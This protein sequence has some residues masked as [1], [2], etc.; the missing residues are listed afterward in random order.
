MNHL[1]SGVP[2]L[3]LQAQ[4]RAVQP[5]IESALLRVAA[6]QICV[7]GPEVE[8]LE[9]VLAEYCGARFALGVSSGTDALLAALMALEIGAGDEVLVPTF[10]FFA[11]A[12]AVAR[13]GATPVFVDSEPRGGM[14]NVEDLERRA[15]PRTKAIIPVH[16]FGQCAAMD[17][18]TDFAK[19]RGIVVIEDAAQ[20]LGA[21]YAPE[22]KAGSMGEIA[23]FSF[24]P[25]KNLGALGDAGLITTN[26]E[27][28]YARLKALRNHGMEPR[29][30]HAFVGGNFRMDALQA[31]AL[32]VKFPHLESWHAARRRNAALYNALFVETGL[33]AESRVGAANYSAP[34]CGDFSRCPDCRFSHKNSFDDG[35]AKILLPEALRASSG[36]DNYHIYHQ[37]VVRAARRDDLRAHLT[38]RGI[39]SEIYYP[40]PLHRQKCFA[41]FARQ[42][43][44]SVR[45][46]PIADCWAAHA[47]ALP[48]YPELPEEHIRRVV[49][50]VAEF[51]DSQERETKKRTKCI[52]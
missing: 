20:A 29:Y 23:C 46:F 9:R 13:L 10:S 11:T 15:T 52:N 30:F 44:N 31:A 14:I 12:G 35:A 42:A 1:A 40:L 28:L 19:R 22:R 41:P 39:G 49:R 32:S 17:E 21:E 37:Y 16:L 33:A 51:Y 6:S 43:P 34:S 50:A 24:Y 4:Y 26:D 18:I 48:I 7:L 38:A 8:R 3:D 2:F 45:D 36:A 5:E 25:T 47:L 27:R